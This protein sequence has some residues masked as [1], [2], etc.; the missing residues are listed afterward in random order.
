[1][2]WSL[3]DQTANNPK[4][5]P[6]LEVSEAGEFWWFLHSLSPAD[7]FQVYVGMDTARSVGKR[8]KTLARLA[9]LWYL[10]P[11]FPSPNLSWGVGMCPFF[12]L[13]CSL[14]P[15]CGSVMWGEHSSVRR[16]ST[17]PTACLG[18]G[19]TSVQKETIFVYFGA[20][21]CQVLRHLEL[22]LWEMHRSWVSEWAWQ[23]CLIQT[24]PQP[25]SSFPTSELP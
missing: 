9:L 10:P 14:C 6:A 16:L 20:F 11:F 5:L 3:R 24:F 7:V 8:E 4:M 25:C 21:V 19:M 15:R 12:L 2:L 13:L 18:Q 17:A 1:M 23:I 22:G